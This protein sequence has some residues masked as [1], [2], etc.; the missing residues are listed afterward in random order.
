MKDF[1]KLSKIF[2]ARILHLAG[3]YVELEG[4]SVDEA[5]TGVM[6]FVVSELKR[7][8]DWVEELLCK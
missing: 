4:C 1:N 6:E 7:E 8:I 3:L 5:T 2:E